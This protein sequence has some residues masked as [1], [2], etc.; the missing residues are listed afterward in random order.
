MSEHA[1]VQVLDQTVVDVDPELRILKAADEEVD[2]GAEGQR[3]G[4]MRIGWN[5][6][7][8]KMKLEGFQK[9]GF[10]DEK[11]YWLSKGIGRSTWYRML[12]LAEDF[13]QLTW[14]EFSEMTAENADHLAKLSED[15]R[16]GEVESG[17]GL[18][19]K[20]TYLASI[21]N[22]EEFQKKILE[23]TAKEQNV[24]V[25]EIPVT[26]KLAVFEGQRPVIIAAIEQFQK[27]H[28]LKTPGQALELMALESVGKKAFTSFIQ[29][30]IPK[31]KSALRLAKDCEAESAVESLRET[32]E[33]TIL[34]M[35]WTLDQTGGGKRW[36]S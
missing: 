10:K 20:W 19:D 34:D 5:G 2:A 18:W 30:A 22:E 25:K 28:E 3:K 4:S 23:A 8:I 14:E 13:K 12:R 1:V 21:L 31:L 36:E 33:Q 6:R 7:I 16:Y 32:V 15:E 29:E 26:F 27:E 11:D 9:L 35:A 17:E 24:E